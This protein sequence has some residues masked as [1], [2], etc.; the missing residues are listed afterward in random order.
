MGITFDK[1]DDENFNPLI[2]MSV[3]FSAE[4][5]QDCYSYNAIDAPSEMK[6]CILEEVAKAFD[7]HVINNAPAYASKEWLKN[8]LDT[9]EIKYKQ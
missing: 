4:L 6:L 3:P 5:V 9:I 8:K 1:K 7:E 2:V